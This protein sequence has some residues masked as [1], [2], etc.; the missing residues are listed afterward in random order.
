MLPPNETSWSFQFSKV[1]QGGKN[2]PC[3]NVTFC[4]NHK[5]LKKQ[6]YVTFGLERAGH[7]VEVPEQWG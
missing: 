5:D 4:Q 7:P 1:G 6:G 2:L 3:I